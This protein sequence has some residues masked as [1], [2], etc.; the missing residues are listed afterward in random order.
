MYWWYQKTS[1]NI[2]CFITMEP[3]DNPLDPLNDPSL[4]EKQKERIIRIRAERKAKKKA[5]REAEM[6]LPIPVPK[7]LSEALPKALPKALIKDIIMSVAIF[8]HGCEDFDRPL[9]DDLADYYR[10]NVRV[11]SRACVPGIISVGNIIENEDIIRAVRGSF[12]G[13]ELV[14]GTEFVHGTDYVINKYIED[15]KPKYLDRVRGFHEGIREK[16]DAKAAKAADD[17]F[18]Q[19]SSGL[20]TFLFEKEF[21]FYEDRPDEKLSSLKEPVKGKYPTLGVHV[22]NVSMKITNDDGSV[23]YESIFDPSDE[24][25]RRFDLTMFNLIYKDGLKQLLDELGQKSLVNEAQTC[26]GFTRIKTRVSTRVSTL[27]LTQLYRFF[28]LMGVRYVNIMDYTCRSCASNM[29]QS[30]L[31]NI[32]RIEQEHVDVKR[33]LFG[34]NKRSTNK[35]SS[36]KKLD[37]KKRRK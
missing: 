34:G 36:K 31:E 30:I 37:T 14:G 18:L 33:G 4:T 13:T 7:A 19:R 1:G 17:R 20:S 24:R 9:T 25:F 15:T 16:T 27:S 23:H 35:R 28:Q 12:S 21:G 22:V 5:E 26:L 32:Y 29:N 10:N 3:I 8:G 2:Y 6:G 11:Y